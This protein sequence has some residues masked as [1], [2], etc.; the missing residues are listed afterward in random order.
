VIKGR[1]QVFKEKKVAIRFSYFVLRYS[2]PVLVLIT[3]FVPDK[4]PTYFSAIALLLIGA[5]LVAWLSSPRWMSGVLRLSLYLLVP[6]LI[7]FSQVDPSP[8]FEENMFRR[9][10]LLLSGAIIFFAVMTLK[11]TMRRKGFKATPMDFLILF[12]ALVVPNLPGLGVKGHGLGLMA[13]QI[14]VILFSYEVLIGELRDELKGLG[15]AT[16]I[17]LGVMAVR[18]LI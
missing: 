13:A 9:L 16:M 14:I 2:L 5:L 12:I 7:Y 18:G 11:F 3:C 1:L 10:Y 4:L 8:L 15:L 17:A 6:Y